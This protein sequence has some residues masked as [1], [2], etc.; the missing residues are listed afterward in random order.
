MEETGE[1]QDI[2]YYGDGIK[3]TRDMDNYFYWVSIN[4][5]NFSFPEKGF[6]QTF[7]ECPSE[8]EL[9]RRISAVYPEISE[10]VSPSD[11][12]K[13]KKAIEETYAKD[14]RE[15]QEWQTKCCRISE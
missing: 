7:G 6:F 8:S 15:F 10:V 14:E 9:M 13:I 4:E 1:L 12:G 11:Y 5:V 3:I 2:L